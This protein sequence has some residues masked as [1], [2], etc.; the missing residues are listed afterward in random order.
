MKG[1]SLE[2]LM[3]VEI[4]LIGFLLDLLMI[5]NFVIQLSCEKSRL[6]RHK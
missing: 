5:L 2:V 6:L 4:L 1:I 3:F